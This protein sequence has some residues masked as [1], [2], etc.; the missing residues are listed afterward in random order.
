MEE[1]F[2]YWLNHDSESFQYALY[3]VLLVILVT[4]EIIIPFRKQNVISKGRWF[5]N[6]A[7][8]FL[9]IMVMGALPISFFTAS[10]FAANHG[11]GLL[12]L[13][14]IPFVLTILLTLLLRGFI[15]F[16]THYLSHKVPLLWRIHRVHHSDT[17]FDVST[18]VR[19][20]PLEFVANLII[21]LPLIFLFGLSSWALLFYDLFDLVITLFSHSNFVIPQKIERILRY[22]IVTPDLHRVHHSSYQPETDSN[23]SAVFPIWDVV[24]KTFKTKTRV[25]QELMEIGLEEVRDKRANNVWWLLISPFKNFRDPE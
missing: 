9:N 25:P 19:F 5:A 11:W 21:G 1:K 24:F 3:G 15:S 18:T 22:V 14:Q 12:N 17:E 6:Y 23:F 4:I 20:H 8:T 10:L 13:F 2:I 7:I 16:F